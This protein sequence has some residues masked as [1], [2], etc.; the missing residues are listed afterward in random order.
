MLGM[1]GADLVTAIGEVEPGCGELRSQVGK[2]RLRGGRE[3]AQVRS[4]AGA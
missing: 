2:I 1:A 3:A 4:A